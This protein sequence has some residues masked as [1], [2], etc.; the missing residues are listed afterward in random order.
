[1]GKVLAIRWFLLVPLRIPKNIDWYRSKLFVPRLLRPR[2]IDILS[3]VSLA[4]FFTGRYMSNF[5]QMCLKAR[6]ILKHSY[7]PYSHFP[8]SCVIRSKN[9]SIFAGVNMENAAYPEGICAEGTALGQMI[10]AGERE[11]VEVVICAQGSTLCFPCGGC[12]QKLAEFSTE[13]TLVHICHAKN[14]SLHT[15]NMGEL[16]PHS[17]TKRD[18]ED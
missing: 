12:R 4:L 5:D 2:T 13:N 3:S 6:E 18:M 1:M 11:V 16:L 10:S 15:T 14:D 8:V 9:G 17:F 7:S